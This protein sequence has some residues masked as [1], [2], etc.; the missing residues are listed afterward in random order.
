MRDFAVDRSEELFALELQ[1]LL[2]TSEAT[3]SR[4]FSLL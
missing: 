2:L 4:S 3:T 1:M